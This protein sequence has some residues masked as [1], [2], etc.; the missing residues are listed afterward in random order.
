MSTPRPTTRRRTAK[1]ATATG[2]KAKA[3]RVERM[4]F[5]EWLKPRAKIGTR[6]DD[7]ENAPPQFSV[8]PNGATNLEWCKAMAAKH[9]SE[10]T[11]CEVLTH[12]LTGL[13]AIGRGV[14]A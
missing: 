13:V 7:G 6:L 4:A 10:G 9:H 8:V 3:R 2:D 12:P 1:M 5:T 11:A 14:T